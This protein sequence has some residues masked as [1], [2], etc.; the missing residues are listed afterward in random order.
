V[1]S[2][3]CILGGIKSEGRGHLTLTEIRGSILIRSVVHFDVV[4]AFN[5]IFQ[6]IPVEEL[7]AT[8]A[9]GKIFFA[10]VPLL[11]GPE[12]KILTQEDVEGG[13]DGFSDI[14]SYERYGIETLEDHADL[15]CQKPLVSTS[16]WNLLTLARRGHVAL[17]FASIRLIKP[18]PISAT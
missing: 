11:K 8:L 2:L 10:H 15:G 18:M 1:E 6:T 3:V 4:D 14:V 7:I 9:A 16:W 5:D 17:T 12:S 13:I